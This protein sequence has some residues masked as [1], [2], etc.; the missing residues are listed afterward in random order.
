MAILRVGTALP[1]DMRNPQ[2]FYGTATIATSTQVEI[3]SGALK[4]DYFGQGL[5]YSSSGGVV[6]GTVTGYSTTYNGGAVYSVIGLNISAAMVYQLVQNGNPLQLSALALSGDDTFYGAGDSDVMVGYGGNNTFNG[7]PSGV[8]Y[9]AYSGPASAYTVTANATGFQVGRPDGG[10]DQLTNIKGIDFSDKTLSLTSTS[11][12]GSGGATDYP[13]ISGRT[14]GIYRFF[15]KVDGTHFFTASTSE[16]KT[17]AGTR[18]DLTFEG[19]GLSAVNPANLSNDAAAVQVYRFFDTIHGTHFYTV[20]QSEEQT[21]VSTRPDLKYEG[22]AFYAD[23][24]KQSGDAAVYRF[25]D[26]GNGTHFY[27]GSASEAQQITATRQD[28]KAEGVAF[29]VPTS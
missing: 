4:G 3:V 1:F 2:V 19:V 9:V 15:S 10:I 27:T 5:A 18:S 12:I 11:G 14:I 22:T 21:I 28:L 13:V 23:A 29:Y 26:I 16:E 7:V 20:N 25:F 24:S 17:I 6:G 8:D